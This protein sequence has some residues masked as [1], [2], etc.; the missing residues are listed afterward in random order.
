MKKLTKPQIYAIIG[1][2]VVASIITFVVIRRRKN[3]K[4]IKQI[5]DILD[6]KVVDPNV[7][8]G[9]NI[10]TPSQLNALPKGNF[11]LKIGDKNQKV[12][13]VQQALNKKFGSNIDM[14]GK[15]GESTFQSMCSN[16]WNK[17]FGSSYYASCFNVGLSG[18]SRRTI[19]Q[20]DW[21]ELQKSANFSGVDGLGLEGE[22]LDG[23]DR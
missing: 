11:P 13:A 10:I 8:A 21:E 9:T 3:K 16:V 23:L 19:T 22:P 6:S 17:G 4:L 7:S 2:V 12:Y 18:A 5:N 1:G 20:R 14:D 15:Y